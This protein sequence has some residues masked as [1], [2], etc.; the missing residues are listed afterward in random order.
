[1]A[2]AL[3]AAGIF[4]QA[5]A[6]PIAPPAYGECRNASGQSV[7]YIPLP[8]PMFKQMFPGYRFGVAIPTIYGPV[9]MYDYQ[10][11]G[12]FPAQTQE[13]ILWHECAH[14]ELGHMNQSAAYGGH[15]VAQRKQSEREAD[16]QS[17]KSVILRRNFSNDDLEI[18]LEGI[19]NSG[20]YEI[21][22]H[23]GA[24]TR[25]ARIRSCALPK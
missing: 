15:D 2:I 14:H 19:L 6:A 10:D 22:T 9:V 13:I 5:N 23:D 12:Q 16:C 18:G 7:S 3:V 11:L 8:P 1:M 21:P 20:M 17:G 4:T 25:A 24:E